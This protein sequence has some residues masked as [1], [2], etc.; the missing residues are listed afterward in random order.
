M[1]LSNGFIGFIIMFELTFELLGAPD[2]MTI[3]EEGFLWV[4][5]YGDY[6]VRRI[7]P[8]GDIVMK[9]DLPVSNITSCAFGGKN[10]ETLFITSAK[11]DLK[12]SE[13]FE[14]KLAGQVISL[15][16]LKAIEKG[17]KTALYAGPIAG[18]SV[19]GVK[20]TLLS[21]FVPLFSL[22]SFLPLFFLPSSFLHPSFLHHSFLPSLSSSFLPSSYNNFI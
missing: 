20:T 6:C 18:Y 5:F 11:K 22:P 16:C 8:K 3:D 15:V 19:V 10:L 4:A 1:L 2:G 9:I 12:E 14:Q 17:L 21:S 7:S 13:L